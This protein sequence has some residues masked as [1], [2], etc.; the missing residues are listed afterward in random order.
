MKNSEALL[1]SSFAPRTSNLF[2]QPRS[3][4]SSLP[5]AAKD[6]YDILGVKKNANDDELKMR[7]YADP[8]FRKKLHYEVIEL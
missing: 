7:M 5:M 4:Y 6:Y 3:L 1:H 8:E 2:R